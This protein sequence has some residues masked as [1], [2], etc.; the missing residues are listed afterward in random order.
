MLFAGAMQVFCLV[1]FYKSIF[2]ALV[3]RLLLFRKQD[4]PKDSGRE[5]TTE[6]G[7]KTL[8]RGKLCQSCA[9]ACHGL[10]AYGLIHYYANTL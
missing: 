10:V 7:V 4:A 2:A 8:R 9:G 1:L 3:R 5:G 6:G